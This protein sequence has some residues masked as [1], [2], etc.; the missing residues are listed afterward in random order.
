MW[1]IGR[2]SL[3]HTLHAGLSFPRNR[4]CVTQ[5]VEKKD[6][7]GL[8]ASFEISLRFNDL[9]EKINNAH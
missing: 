7:A 5:G 9:A 4:G 3:M 1:L 2:I 8:T 6:A